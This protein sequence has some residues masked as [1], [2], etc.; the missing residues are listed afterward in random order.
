MPGRPGGAAASVWLLWLL[1]AHAP[2]AAQGEPAAPPDTAAPAPQGAQAAEAPQEA[3]T[4]EEA[5]ETG[6]RVAA[7]ELRS[8]APLDDEID[9]EALLDV[10]VGEPLTDRRVRRTLRNIQ[11]S[12]IASQVEVYSRPAAGVPARA[13]EVEVIVVLRPPL[14]VE[15][16]RIEGDLGLSR[17][18]L[19]GAIEP[20]EGLPL[21]EERVL[22]S[23]FRLQDL[24]E[25]RGYLQARVRPL[26]TVDEER[27][28]ATIVYE[29]ASGPRA[30]VGSISFEGP[31]APFKPADLVERLRVKPGEAYRK[32]A[33]ADDA[34]RLK[35]WLVRQHHNLADVDPP[36]EQIDEGRTRV[37]LTYPIDVGPR[38]EVEV[39]GAELKRLRRRGLLPFLDDEGYDEAL[40]LQSVAKIKDY[41]QGEGH[42]HVVVDSAETREDG[43]LRLA[44]RIEPGPKYTLTEVDFEGNQ[45]VSEEQLADLM[46]T[47][48]RRLLSLGSG[49]LVEAELDKDVDNIRSYYALQ[50]YVEAE[51]GTPQVYESGDTLR[52]VIPID[53]GPRLTVGSIHFIGLD[54]LDLGAL[55]QQLSLKD[56]G[57]FHPVLIEDTLDA[58]RA[59][60]AAEGYV[61][62]QVSASEAW[63]PDHTVVD[64]TIEAIAG[65]R[66]VVDRIIVR[67]NRRTVTDVIRRTTGLERGEPISATR[68]LEVQRDLYR[69][70]I[71][72]RVDAELTRPGLAPTSRDVVI[73]VQEGAPRTLT[74]GVG[75]DSEDGAR[76]LL[77]FTHNNVAGRAYSLVTDLRLS[78]RDRRARVIFD[79]PYLGRLPIP[80]TSSLFYLQED[81][82]DSEVAGVATRKWGGRTEASKIL[83]LT[84]YGLV[85]DYRVVEADLDDGVALND[86]ERENRP[87][88]IASVIPNVLLDHRDDPVLPSRGWSSLVQ[89][90]YSFPAL[91][92][93]AE[94]LK[95]FLQHTQYLRLGR[96]GVVAASGRLGAIEPF[97]QLG[98]DDPDLPEDLPNADVFISERF[99]LGGSTTHRAYRRDELGIPGQTLFP[100][101]PDR[102]G[103]DF[104]AVGGNGLLLFNI[105]YRFPIAGPVGGTVFYDLGNVWAGW[106]DIDFGETKGGVGVGV[107]YISPIGPLR[108]EVG[109]KLDRERFE[110]SRPVYFLSFGNPF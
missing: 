81:E 1:L 100:R 80:L 72:T 12:G 103:E 31:I 22:Q 19:Q 25:E 28:L 87:L 71:F 65:P 38:L 86:I 85:F 2:A 20:A 67:G 108:V 37:D 94:F 16:V 30:V 75:Y 89:T 5:V 24:Y 8:E 95:V 44:I 64:L 33:L 83:G 42:Y 57:P 35:T 61:E 6:P 93:Q 76:G 97:Q 45:G 88:Q 13:G 106:R 99:F 68:L 107:R 56:G 49:R 34:E 4:P 92:S 79:Q 10:A 66:A 46:T 55:R 47:S 14:K 84:R 59:A 29:V 110:S 91:G 105:D 69:L 18:E 3:A 73:R 27:R 82:A 58:I 36:R 62:A 15:E 53:E 41:Y 17:E 63:N 96:T 50:G 74:Y 109:W 11:A 102:P 51:V 23:V 48:P 7:I 101:D 21:A 78:Q 52:L 90:Q 43:V 60:F 70:G 26:V 9:V 104:R 40:V 77:G 39:R 98:G 54:A 32:D